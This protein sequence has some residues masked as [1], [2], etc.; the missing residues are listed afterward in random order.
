MGLSA[1]N[2]GI[3]RGAM[4][5]LRWILV[6]RQ[7]TSGLD[8][9]NMISDSL[10]ARISIHPYHPIPLIRHSKNQRRWT[11]PGRLKQSDH[12]RPALLLAL[13]LL[14]FPPSSFLSVFVLALF[15]VVSLRR[16]PLAGPLVRAACCQ[17][18]APRLFILGCI[19][20]PPHSRELGGSRGKCVH[21]TIRYQQV[22]RSGPPTG[23]I[24]Q[25]EPH[26]WG[27]LGSRMDQIR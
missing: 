24:P 22:W 3:L 18:A 2:M 1:Q 5:A 26:A 6:R 23:A 19:P 10:N 14:V 4:S 13:I 27:R 17:H 8:A 21:W 11:V 25:S 9:P 7:S 12:Q 15:R 20:P 16:F